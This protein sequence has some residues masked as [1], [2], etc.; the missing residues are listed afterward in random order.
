MPLYEVFIKPG[1]TSQ[2]LEAPNAEEAK[3]MFVELLTD[4]L[5]TDQV[6]ANCLDDD[7]DAISE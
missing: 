5:D 1:W 3:R 4:N 7:E 6:E 2:D